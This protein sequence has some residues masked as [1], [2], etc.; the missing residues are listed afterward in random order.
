MPLIFLFKTRPKG[1]EYGMVKFP[2]FWENI[3]PFFDKK[4]L[5][6]FY[7]GYSCLIAV[8]SPENKLP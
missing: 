3:S 5:D 6:L 1:I 2:A 8:I 7:C 4:I